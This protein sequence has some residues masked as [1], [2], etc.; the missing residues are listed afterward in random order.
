MNTGNDAFLPVGSIIK[1]HGLNGEVVVEPV[2]DYPEQLEE[3]DLFYIRN[4]RGD[5]LPVR[6]ESSRLLQKGFRTSFFVKFVQITDRNEA[7]SVKGQQL[8]LPADEVEHDSEEET[9]LLSYIGFRVISVEGD[10]YGEILDVLD[11]PAH[12]ILEVSG[13]HGRFLIPMVD[14][15]IVNIDEEK[16]QIIGR[17]LEQL[18]QV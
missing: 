17:N 12:P 9:D 10:V 18:T 5:W 15:Y 4:K 6:V 2:I 3:K 7:E 11:N 1:I 13:D 8:Y 16:Q 14:A